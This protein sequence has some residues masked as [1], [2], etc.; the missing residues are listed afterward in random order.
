MQQRVPG[1]HGIRVRLVLQ[2]AAELRV[3]GRTVAVQ[4]VS[5]SVVKPIQQGQAGVAG[6]PRSRHS[7]VI[8]FRKVDAGFA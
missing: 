5:G 4:S 3:P 8:Q 1:G 7:G 2:R 6:P